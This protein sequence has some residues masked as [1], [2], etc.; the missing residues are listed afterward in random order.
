MLPFNKLSF[1]VS[2]WG[3]LFV[4]IRKRESTFYAKTWH[5]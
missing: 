2:I 1:F 3:M 4:P 5:F